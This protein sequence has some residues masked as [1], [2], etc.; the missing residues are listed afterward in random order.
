MNDVFKVNGFVGKKGDDYYF[1]KDWIINDYG[2]INEGKIYS[3][4]YKNSIY[5]PKVNP[6]LI[7]NQIQ[8]AIQDAQ[9]KSKTKTQ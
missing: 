1:Q 2:L 6:D 3:L 8:A 4:V 9:K 7:I 5:N